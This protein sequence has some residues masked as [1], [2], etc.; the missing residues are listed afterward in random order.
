MATDGAATDQLAHSY[1]KWDSVD[2][3][4][5]ED[6]KAARQAEKDKRK[7]HSDE[8]REK[9]AV[10]RAQMM[11]KSGVAA[12][13]P[14]KLPMPTRAPGAPGPPTMMEAGSALDP[15]K[16]TADQRQEFTEQYSKIFNR[17][18]PKKRD[19]KF[20][21]TFEE[22]KERVDEADA[23]RLRG[24]AYFKK[25]ELMEAAKLYEQAVLKFADWCAPIH[26]NPWRHVTCPR[27]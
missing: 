8:A 25:G 1:S 12:P 7:K 5:D 15:E 18:L 22:Q 13:E 20:P 26:G 11:A 10:E 2:Y 9:A 21:D 14:P 3:D 6:E 19:Y 24:N 17:N 4:T 27:H 16:M 23:L